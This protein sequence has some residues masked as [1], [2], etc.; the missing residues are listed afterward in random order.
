MRRGF[1]FAPTQ[2]DNLEYALKLQL[3]E[4]VKDGVLDALPGDCY[5]VKLEG[6]EVK[7]KSP[8]STSASTPTKSKGGYT[9]APSIPF[10]VKF[11][12]EEVKEKT[13]VMTFI[14]SLQ[15]I[16]LSKVQSVGIMRKG[17][18][19]VS[20]I[21][22]PPDGKSKQQDYVDGKYIY[23]KLGN[24]DKKGYLYQ[25]ANELGINIKIYDI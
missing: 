11:P 20:D 1:A 8:A 23:T 17:Y 6:I 15:H 21:E 22:C 25:I 3:E 5:S 10:A 19:L 12:D 2:C 9:K 24:Q 18:N 14:K 13:A 4:L 7:P 16:G